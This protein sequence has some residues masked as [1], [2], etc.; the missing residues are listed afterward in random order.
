MTDA[1][2]LAI[3]PQEGCGINGTSREFITTIS[4]AMHRLQARRAGFYKPATGFVSQPEP[5]SIGSFAKGRQLAAGNIMLAGH[6]IEAP[7]AMLWDIDPPDLVFA[8]DAHG[9]AWLDD[10]AAAAT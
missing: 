1:N 4:T 8:Q 7:N 6:L 3:V 9:F 2:L 5:R 10:L